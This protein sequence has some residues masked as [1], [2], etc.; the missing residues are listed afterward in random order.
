MSGRPA[1]RTGRGLF[2]SGV[3][4]AAAFAVLVSLGFWQVQRLAWK[5]G[6]IVRIEAGLAAAPVPLSEIAIALARGHDA[7]WRKAEAHGRFRHDL[8]RHLYDIES[9][10]AG[11][12]VLTPLESA[13]GPV[14]W[15]DRGFVP[16]ER[17]QPASRAAGQLAGDIGVTGLV[18]VPPP[19]RP[20]FVPANEPGRNIWYWPDLAAMGTGATPPLAGTVL[21]V[22]LEASGPPPPGGWPRPRQRTQA[23]IP[24]NHLGY[25][26]TWF[27]LAA[28]LAGVYIA[29][30]ITS[31]RAGR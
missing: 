15:V 19:A 13:G 17:K 10:R 9:G 30:A 2:W 11:Y 12:R 16:E 8:E 4:S 28:A 26:L 20:T 1:G 7:D 18:R 25:A 24:N 5:T 29:F 14:V 21:P 6:L 22:I 23:D 3:A 27:G 31:R